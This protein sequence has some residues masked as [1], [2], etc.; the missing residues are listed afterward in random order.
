MGKILLDA[1]VDEDAVVSWG[2]GMVDGSEL[3]GGNPRIV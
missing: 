1:T 3:G 2:E